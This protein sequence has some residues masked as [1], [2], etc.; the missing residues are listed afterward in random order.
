M[1][2]S[3]IVAIG[4]QN[5]FLLRQAILRSHVTVLVLIC[6]LSDVILVAAGVSGLGAIVQHVPMAMLLIR[7]C[8]ALLLLGYAAMAVRRV[9]T[10]EHLDVDGVGARRSLA[11]AIA[12]CLAITWLNPH[13]YLDTLLMIGA[14]ANTHGPHRWW[15]A[16]GSML[17]SIS[18]FAALGYGPRLL[19]PVFR[20]PRAWRILDSAIAMIMVA[21]AVRLLVS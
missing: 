4:A 2:M 3:L 9:V 13:V 21:T 8:G 15:F 10:G 1:M 19:R 7:A 11:S 5:T 17:A 14:V 16:G 6:W 20:T 12:T 18:W